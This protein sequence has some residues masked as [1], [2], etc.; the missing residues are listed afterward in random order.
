MQQF[1]QWIGSKAVWSSSRFSDLPRLKFEEG[2]L[3]HHWCVVGGGLALILSRASDA[4][5]ATR[6]TASAQLYEHVRSR[7]RQGLRPEPGGSLMAEVVH[8]TT[9]LADPMTRASLG[10]CFRECLKQQGAAEDSRP[11]PVTLASTTSIVPSRRAS[12]GLDDLDDMPTQINSELLH[13]RSRTLRHA[14]AAART[15]FAE[16]K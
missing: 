1:M 14:V 10:T 15:N 2:S 4:E 5:R 6:L 8:E 3:A 9:H 11:A 13:Q 12:S 16:L 7:L